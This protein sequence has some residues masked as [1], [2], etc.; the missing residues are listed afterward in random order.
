MTGSL[1]K[2]KRSLE[3]QKHVEKSH[4]FFK[5]VTLYISEPSLNLI[6]HYDENPDLKSDQE[7]AA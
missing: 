7:T 1:K 5:T 3:K 4:R 2:R 6:R